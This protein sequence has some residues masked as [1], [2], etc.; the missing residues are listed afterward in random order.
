MDDSSSTR[1]RTDADPLPNLADLVPLA[2]V[3]D[4]VPPSANGRRIHIS[5]PHRWV[6]RGIA[7]V[8][9]RVVSLG[10][11]RMTTARWLAEFAA[12]VAAAREPTPAPTRRRANGRRTPR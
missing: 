2:A 9:L 5:A 1:S 3:P 10:G 8:R 7:G 11:R 4:L 6:A 12:A